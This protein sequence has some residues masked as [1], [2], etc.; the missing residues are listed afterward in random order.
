[1]PIRVLCSLASLLLLLSLEAWAEESCRTCHPD[2]RIEY[3]TSVHGKEFSC[4]VCHGGDPAVLTVEAHSLQKKYIGKPLRPEVPALCASCHADPNRMKPFGLPTDQYA[5]YLTSQ[6]GLLLAKGDTHVAVCTDCH[7]VHGILPR[8]EP[9]SPV[10]VRNIPTTCGRCHADQ[11]LMA[12]Y[13][14]PADQVDKFRRSVHGEALFVDQHP[15]APTCTTCH[16]EH[17]AAPLE[18]AAGTVCGHCHARTREYFNESP[19]KKAVE[20][21]KMSECVSCH[22]YH[23][24][25]R[26]D[27]LIFDT[28]CPSCHARDSAA[29]L[30]GQKLKTIL[31]QTNE[32][33]ETALSELTEFEEFSPTIT[34]YRP[35]LQQARAHFM[36][37]LPVQHSLNTDRVEDLTRNAR[38]IG[39]EVRASV[40]GVQEE[41][42]LRYIVLAV[43]WVLLLFAVGIAYLYRQERRRLRAKAEAEARRALDEAGTSD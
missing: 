33:L 28:A 18:G 15:S 43:V 39:E 41:M 25:P 23:D 11:E 38:S 5:Q 17:G 42:R 34:R 32:S 19:H 16:G 21:Q 4:T 40:H 31:A 26:P 2:V 3:E 37:A 8:G 24:T 36:E 30:T 9:N 13:K 27:R 29:F 12:T 35:R 20:E 14:L 22:G 7:G 1:M 6:H 10:A